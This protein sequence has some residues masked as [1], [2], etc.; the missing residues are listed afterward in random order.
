MYEIL[1]MNRIFIGLLGLFPKTKCS[2]AK[3]VRN[4]GGGLYSSGLDTGGSSPSSH[5]STFILA[6]ALLILKLEALDPI[7]LV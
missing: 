4:F 2:F 7:L 5:P 3:V 1:Y 6:S